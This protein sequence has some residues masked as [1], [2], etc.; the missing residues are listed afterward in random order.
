MYMCTYVCTWSLFIPLLLPLQ[1]LSGLWFRSV[2]L[3]SNFV[4]FRISGTL[5]SCC[6]TRVNASC[7]AYL[8]LGPDFHPFLDLILV[9]LSEGMWQLLDYQ[10]C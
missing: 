8:V 2:T 7:H 3:L 4:R 6:H 5:R 10:T 9:L 1:C